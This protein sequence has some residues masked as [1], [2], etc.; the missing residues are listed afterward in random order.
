MTNFYILGVTGLG[1]R[2]RRYTWPGV[3]ERIIVQ[4]SHKIGFEGAPPFRRN[5]E[6][7]PEEINKWLIFVPD[8]FGLVHLCRVPH[9][10]GSECEHEIGT[11]D[12]FKALLVSA[13]REAVA[14][15]KQEAYEEAE[16]VATEQ[17]K[18]WGSGAYEARHAITGVVTAI[19]ELN[20]SRSQETEK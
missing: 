19:R 18:E 14:Q 13:I 7:T 15:A 1:N 10:H 12:N 16:R 17:L 8:A 20:R 3:R 2:N 5:K 4:L 11:M 6:M 9:E